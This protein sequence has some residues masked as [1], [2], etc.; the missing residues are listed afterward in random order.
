MA[1]VPNHQIVFK[2][3]NGIGGSLTDYG[4]QITEIDLP[5][6][7]MSASHHTFASRYQ[8]ATVGGLKH[9]IKIKVRVE[10][11]ATSL[12]GILFMNAHSAT[13]AT[14]NGTYTFQVG[15]PDVT[16]TGS[17]TLTGE[18]K[19]TK[20]GSPYKAGAGKGEIQICDYELTTDGALTPGVV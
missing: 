16:T 6:E 19:L 1:T 20:A 13:P 4:G 14:Y 18:C 9:T 15:T 2:L 12:H 3:D 11:T 5:V 17:L 10:T 8:N 7:I